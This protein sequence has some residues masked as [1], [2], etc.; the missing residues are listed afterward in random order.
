M[1]AIKKTEL[2]T[3]FTELAPI[4]A[5]LKEHRDCTVVALTIVTGLS[6][7]VCHKAMADAGRKSRRGAY[8]DQW[9]AAANALGFHLRQ[10]TSSE[11][12]GMV[13]SYPSPHNRLHGIT[14]HHPRRFAKCWAGTGKL[15]LQSRGHVSACVDGVVADWAINRSKQVHTIFTVERLSQ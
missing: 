13:R 11:M 3:A 1:P 10:W 12:V 5:E 7:A 14:T 15:L 6:Y 4:R 8:Q 9:E 2:P